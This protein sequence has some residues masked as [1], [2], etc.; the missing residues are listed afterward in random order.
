MFSGK[1]EPISKNAHLEISGRRGSLKNKG[2][3]AISNGQKH[4]FLSWGK[5][6]VK[7]R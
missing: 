5:S 1:K 3:P 6:K 7:V 4:P 2:N